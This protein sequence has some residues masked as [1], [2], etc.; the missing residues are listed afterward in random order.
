[1][2]KK[3][4]ASAKLVRQRT[5]LLRERERITKPWRLAIFEL[6]NQLA[7]DC[8][9]NNAQFRRFQKRRLIENLANEIRETRRVASS[10]VMSY[11]LFCGS[12]WQEQLGYNEARGQH[13]AELT[14]LGFSKE[15]Q[16][17]ANLDTSAD[18]LL[19][20][21]DS[22]A[23]WIEAH[24]S[25]IFWTRL[26]HNAAAWDPHDSITRRQAMDAAIVAKLPTLIGTLS[27]WGLARTVEGFATW[28]VPQW[29][30][31][32]KIAAGIARETHPISQM[33]AWVWWRY[34]IFSRYH[35][36]ASE[37]L[38]AARK[39]FGDTAEFDNEAAFQ[40]AWV[41]RGLRFTG[42]RRKRRQPPLWSFVV[43]EP[44]PEN[45]SSK[46]SMLTWF[47]YEKSR[48]RS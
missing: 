7:S 42:R 45:I 20:R 34:P 16:P 37:V 18:E 36:S 6:R 29:G 2:A 47:P 25:F 11:W 41:R 24:E 8:L 19:F 4:R 12:P 31:I 22:L 38:R 27:D 46:Y 26:A 14:S 30:K 28:K 32:L 44:V 43:T 33:D 1:M 17:T 35:W 23:C 21:L 48:S 9:S 40:S 15:F 5:W 3:R 39:R 13:H 10:T